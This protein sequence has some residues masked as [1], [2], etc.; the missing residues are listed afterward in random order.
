MLPAINRSLQRLLYERGNIEPREV[1]ISFDAPTRERTE[2][3]IQPTIYL[4]LYDMQ[5]NL[6]LR[7]SGMETTRN[8]GRALHRLAFRLFDLHYMICAPMSNIEDEHQLLWRALTTLVRHAQLPPEMLDEELRS[9]DPVPQGRLYHDNDIQRSLSLWSG[10]AM[11]P[12]PSFFYA[13]TVPVAMDVLSDAPLV[14]MRT[15]RYRAINSENSEQEARYQV[16]GVVRDKQGVPLAGVTL[17]LDGRAMT[18]VT[19][20]EGQFVLRDIVPGALHLRITRGSGTPQFFVIEIPAEPLH[21]ESTSQFS[22]QLFYTIILESDTVSDR[23][24]S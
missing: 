1:E 14:L 9:L 15:A 13:V 19:N 21:G 2:R 16:G 12:R 18:Y 3:Q 17:T 11:S 24:I 6:E 5:E 7:H 4:Y 23:T 22:H 10:L 20:S 8:N